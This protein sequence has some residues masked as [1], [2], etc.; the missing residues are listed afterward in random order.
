MG[1][2]VPLPADLGKVLREGRIDTLMLPAGVSNLQ[3]AKSWR[4]RGLILR[5]SGITS[6]EGLPEGLELL[7]L[8]DCPAVSEL[9]LSSDLRFLDITGT[10]VVELHGSYDRLKNL[11]MGFEQKTI[12]QDIN[13]RLSNLSGLFLT[14]G[15]DQDWTALLERIPSALRVLSLGGVSFDRLGSSLSQLEE[16]WLEETLVRDLKTVR[17]SK[18]HHVVL[19]GN[20]RLGGRDFPEFLLDLEY[21]G[22]ENTAID[23]GRLLS[24]DRLIWV[25]GNV[26]NLHS[27]P[28]TVT[29]LGF[30]RCEQL[31]FRGF[32]PDDDCLSLETESLLERPPSIARLEIEGPVETLC[33]GLPVDALTITG[34][35]LRRGEIDFQSLLCP[36]LNGNHQSSVMSFD[37]LR[38]LEIR[39][40]MTLKAIKGLDTIVPSLVELAVVN[41]PLQTLPPLP[42]SLKILDIRRTS[43]TQLPQELRDHPALEVLIVDP[44]Q[45]QSLENLPASVRSLYFVEANIDIETPFLRASLGGR[46]GVKY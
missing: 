11:G 27:L 12:L 10:S 9:P 33:S 4:I 20:S 44:A 14:G 26:V 28:S 21:A 2:S 5:G 17:K 13:H 46:Y 41:V 25:R 23:A 34:Q 32:P 42:R 7:D 15:G 45:L 22:T 36:P 39:N 43:V 3:D 35:A 31:R 37:N 18:L 16:L 6:L 8:H 40:S 29:H 19:R 30:P 1:A 38:R 24:I